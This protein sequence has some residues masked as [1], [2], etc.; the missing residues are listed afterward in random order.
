MSNYIIVN[1]E[2]YHHGIKGM[3]W[4]KR[5]FQN[6]DGSLTPAGRKRYSEGD[7]GDRKYVTIRQASKNAKEAQRDAVRKLNESNKKHTAHQYSKAIKNARKE[8]IA[9]D[10]DRNKELRDTPEAKAARKEKAVKAAKVGAAVAGTALAAY[11][12][13]K[14]HEAVKDKNFQIR[15]EQGN[16]VI[17]SYKNAGMPSSRSGD[18]DPN[19]YIKTVKE[20]YE[21]KASS[22]SFAKAAK[23]VATDYLEK[24]KKR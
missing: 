5:R 23:N 6:N 15:V 24:R 13:Y 1:G 3:K 2:L 8:S 9:E 14:V 20:T 19:K 7:N 16:R 17:N 22:D 18:M 4:G 10:K 12:A 21:Q 11:G